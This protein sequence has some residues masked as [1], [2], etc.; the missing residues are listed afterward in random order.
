MG[1]VVT[2]VRRADGEAAAAGTF[3]RGARRARRAVGRAR[4]EQPFATINYA[5]QQ[6]PD[7]ST[8]VV[9]S[10]H[11]PG[12][13]DPG[14]ERYRQGPGAP[15]GDPLPGPAAQ[16]RRPGGPLLRLPGR[17]HRGLRH[18]PRGAGCRAHRGPDRRRRRQG[19]RDIVLRNN[20]LHD[21]YEQRHPQDQQ[22]RARRARG[23]ATS[24]T[25]RPASDEHIDVN[26]VA[27]RDH[28]GQRLL[29]RLRRLEAAPPGDSASFIVIKDS[30]D[31][32]DGILGSQ[33]IT[34][35]RNVFLGWQGG[36]GARLRAGGRGRQAVLRG[37]RRDGREQP[38]PGRL[39]GEPMRSPF[40]VKGGERTIFRNNTVLGD[41]PGKAFATR[42]NREGDN[43]KG[44]TIR[45]YNNV[46]DD[47]TGTMSHFSRHPATTTWASFTHLAQ[48]V[49]GTAARPSPSASRTPST[50]PPT[51]P[52]W[53]PT[54]GCPIRAACARRAGCPTRQTLRRRLAAPSRQAR[55]PDRPLRASRD[56]ARGDGSRG[57]GQR[58]GRRH[59][60][61]K[62]Q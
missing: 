58:A 6:V 16:P 42:I 59:S 11:L 15:L 5:A 53:W 21:S 10:R 30:N 45:F 27:R 7:G 35:R 31:D 52:G 26:S 50:T 23:R 47:P 55:P 29:Q 57:P 61:A 18:R 46:W 37:A 24:S 49:T 19:R 4:S 13:V 32:E 22:R 33:N 62:A 34:V 14:A 8:I 39:V 48:P 17:H 25:T 43:R 41:L 12:S 54:R 51:A 9:A 1:S 40:G 36:S 38:V 2:V 3:Q 60:R 28:R 56:G 20:V 44:E